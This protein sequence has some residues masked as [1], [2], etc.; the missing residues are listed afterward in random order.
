LGLGQATAQENLQEAAFGCQGGGPHQVVPRLG[1]V[2][3]GM[4]DLS[5]EHVNRSRCVA[6]PGR[7]GE[8]QRHID[9]GSG[10][11]QITFPKCDGRGQVMAEASIP[12]PVD[13]GCPGQPPQKTLG[14]GNCAVQ[15][16]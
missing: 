12:G 11:L 2:T 4:L 8:I 1:A 13:L 10:P 5:L 15:P 9:R 6:D 16:I 7:G 14:E 3:P